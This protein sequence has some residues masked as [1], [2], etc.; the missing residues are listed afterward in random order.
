[1]AACTFNYGEA[2]LS[3]KMS[4]AVPNTVLENFQ[5]TV[6]QD[7]KPAFR[8]SA[9][10]AETYD[11]KK[12]TRL[13]G[14]SFVEYDSRTG[15]PITAGTAASAVFFGDSENVELSGAIFFY[16]KRNKFSLEGGY[17]YWDNAKKTL[18][19]RRDRLITL[20]GDDGSVIRGEGFTAD[21]RRRSMSFSG[22]TTGTFIVEDE[23][24]GDASSK[25]AAPSESTAPSE[26]N[27]W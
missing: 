2:D 25:S 13:K 17:L 18:E 4:E 9:A 16:S 5:H 14:V 11:A 12:E 19:G 26:G 20:E 21:A 1:M 15:E 7:G 6:M 8:L 23:E 22:H 27:E 10:R 3:D 24:E